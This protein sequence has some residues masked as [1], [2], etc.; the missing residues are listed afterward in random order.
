MVPTHAD[1]IFHDTWPQRA[2][3]VG[4]WLALEDVSDTAG[5][6]VY[7]NRSHTKGL[8]DFAALN[9]TDASMISRL[10]N[11][12]STYAHTLHEEVRRRGMEPTAALLKR[13]QL[14]IWKGNVLHGGS[15]VLDWNR[16]RKSITT[17]YFLEG[18]RTYWNPLLSAGSGRFRGKIPSFIPPRRKGPPPSGAA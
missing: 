15:Q 12:Y 9:L 7:F 4:T 11:P 16:T 3:L 13:G 6:L 8:W 2:L 18:S 14:L 10:N 1:I 17:H 5:P